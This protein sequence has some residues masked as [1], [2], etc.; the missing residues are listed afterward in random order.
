MN[1]NLQ[2]NINNINLTIDNWLLNK[3]VFL[4]IMSIYLKP[5]LKT[6]TVHWKNNFSPV[7]LTCFCDKTWYYI[8]LLKHKEFTVG[9]M[10][11]NT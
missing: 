7:G 2:Y 8:Y 9:K 10:C 6:V 11:L 1:V 5:T 3:W 4:N